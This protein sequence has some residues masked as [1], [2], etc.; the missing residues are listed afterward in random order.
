[1]FLESARDRRLNVTTMMI[2]NSSECRWSLPDGENDV[3]HHR[4]RRKSPILD[5]DFRRREDLPHR[6][7]PGI[8]GLQNV[9]VS[10][11]GLLFQVANKSREASN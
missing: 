7:F 1:M 6:Q 2:V 3:T 9:C 5:G 8:Q 4:F 10:D 11:H